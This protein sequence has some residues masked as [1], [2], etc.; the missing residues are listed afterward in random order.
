MN[1][2]NLS[3]MSFFIENN[4]KIARNVLIPSYRRNRQ[5]K[6]EKRTRV[7]KLITK[8]RKTLGLQPEIRFT[9][10]YANNGCKLPHIVANN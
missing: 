7:G 2:F 6:E 4:N 10:G 5:M 1:N 3:V 9:L 8:E